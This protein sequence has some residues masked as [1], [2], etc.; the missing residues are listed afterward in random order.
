MVAIFG[1][2]SIPSQEVPSVGLWDEVV[3]KG[4]HILGYGLLAL[5][6]WYALRFDR[7][8]RW[9]VLLF[10]VLFAITDEFHQSFVPGRHSSW[11]DVLVF[12]GG[13]AALMLLVS[14]WV[15]KRMRF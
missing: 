1:Y 5:A 4:A 10:T 7:Q 11:V 12:D 14:T 2:S 9:L 8:R 15:R 13:G 6:T 3:Q